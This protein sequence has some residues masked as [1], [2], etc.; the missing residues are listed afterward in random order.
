MHDALVVRSGKRRGQLT[1][2]RHDLIHRQLLPAEPRRKVLPLD[3]IHHDEDALVVL[4]DVVN[5]GDVWMVDARGRARFPEDSRS[6]VA[7]TAAPGKIS[8]PCAGAMIAAETPF[9]RGQAIDD[10]ETDLTSCRDRAAVQIV[11]HRRLRD[12]APTSPRSERT[13]SSMLV[14]TIAAKA[15]RS[16]GGSSSA[17]AIS[18]FAFSQDAASMSASLHAAFEPQPRSRPLPLHGGR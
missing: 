18:S 1:P 13:S 6:L 16:E 11:E 3:V 17:S 8:A 9:R 14:G 10:D 2:N 15:S 12:P 7:R 4:D 5:S